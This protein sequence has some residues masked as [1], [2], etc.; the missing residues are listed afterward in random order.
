MLEDFIEA[1]SLK[2]KI[3]PGYLK[4]NRIKCRVLFADSKEILAICFVADKLDFEKIKKHLNA[5]ELE[6]ADASA[7]EGRETWTED[8]CTRW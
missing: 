2:A 3:L 4:Q 7:A 1:N 8:A 5:E 6:P